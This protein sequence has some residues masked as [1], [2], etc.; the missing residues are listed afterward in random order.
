MVQPEDLLHHFVETHVLMTRSAIYDAVFKL[1]ESLILYQNGSP[2]AV[3]SKGHD[4][5]HIARKVGG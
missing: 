3:I 5:C 2:E 1:L 4:S